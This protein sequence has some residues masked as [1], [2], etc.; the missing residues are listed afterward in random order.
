MNDFRSRL[1]IHVELEGLNAE[2]VKTAA[3][4]KK[5]FKEVGV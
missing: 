3:T 1:D 5:K 4:I 2:M